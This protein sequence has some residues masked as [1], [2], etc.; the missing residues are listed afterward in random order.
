MG[1]AP[2][3]PARFIA[4]LVPGNAQMVQVASNP[5]RLSTWHKASRLAKV[6]EKVVENSITN[7]RELSH[8]FAAEPRR[9][10]IGPERVANIFITTIP[11]LESIRSRM[12]AR[13]VVLPRRLHRAAQGP[14]FPQPT[15]SPVAADPGNHF[16]ALLQ[17]WDGKVRSKTDF[18]SDSFLCVDGGEIDPG[19]GL[20]SLL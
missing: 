11:K 10:V 5:V 15:C 17:S 8:K 18:A 6:V 14:I 9:L 3:I 1:T 2:C 13:D 19:D 16:L 7:D 12:H 20:I 4:A